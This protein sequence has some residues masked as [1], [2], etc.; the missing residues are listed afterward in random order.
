LL[1][2]KAKNGH[3]TDAQVAFWGAWQ[4]AVDKHIIRSIEEALQV[5]G[6]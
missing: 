2:I 5:V 4:T 6:R 3:L 1:V